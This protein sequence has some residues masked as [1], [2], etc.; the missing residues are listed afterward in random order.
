MNT[1]ILEELWQKHNQLSKIEGKK[2][3]NI[4]IHLYKQEPGCKVQT[5]MNSYVKIQEILLVQY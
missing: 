4:P 1:C 5:F 2:E 3:K